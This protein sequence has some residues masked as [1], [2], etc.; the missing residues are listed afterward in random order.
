MIMIIIIILIANRSKYMQITHI[1]SPNHVNGMPV[2]ALSI[3]PQLRASEVCLTL[4][5]IQSINVHVDVLY[6][7][8]GALLAS[9]DDA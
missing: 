9:V 2:L 4:N 7:R 5:Q 6:H 3:V 8:Q 1:K